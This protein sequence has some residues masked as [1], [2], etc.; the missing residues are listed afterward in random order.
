MKKI[1]FFAILISLSLLFISCGYKPSVIYAKNELEK[2]VYISVDIDIKNARN[3]VLIK[4]ELMKLVR[5]KFNLPIANTKYEASSFLNGKL[6]SVEHK[7]LLSDTSGFA[8]AYRETVNVKITYNKKNKQVKTFIVKNYYDFLVN[9]DSTLTQ[10][11][12]DEAIRIAIS[13]ALS[14]VFSKI[15]INSKNNEN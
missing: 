15:A 11:K 13:K 7:E 14:N 3:S 8:K 1:N 9:S 10:S 12:K 2:K 5:N 4:D 6:L